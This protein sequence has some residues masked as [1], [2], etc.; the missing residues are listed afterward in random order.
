VNAHRS[1]I[2]PLDNENVPPGAFDGSS[3]NCEFGNGSSAGAAFGVK[4]FAPIGKLGWF[5]PRFIYEDHGA[6]FATVSLLPGVGTAIPT[7][8]GQT[9]GSLDIG[10]T[11]LTVDL[12]AAVN[13]RVLNG[14]LALG[15]SFSYVSTADYTMINADRA[16]GTGKYSGEFQDVRAVTYDIRTGLGF[17]IP[18]GRHV[19]I[20]PEGLYSYP[21]TKISKWRDWS[22]RSFQGTLGIM[23][24]L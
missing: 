14:Y 19:A 13:L 12:L 18:V 9:P 7:S 15:P 5:S 4:L 2:T 1:S 16:G 8:A 23:V 24:L 6:S 17:T 22:L 3:C 10:L 20:N 11:T 21:L